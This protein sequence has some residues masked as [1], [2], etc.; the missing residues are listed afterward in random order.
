MLRD[1]SVDHCQPLKMFALIGLL[2]V[3]FLGEI[4]ANAVYICAVYSTPAST[5][6]KHTPKLV[7][8]FRIKGKGE[9]LKLYSNCHP[10]LF[11]FLRLYAFYFAPQTKSFHKNSV[12]CLCLSLWA[13]CSLLSDSTTPSWPLTLFSAGA[14]PLPLPFPMHL[15]APASSSIY[16]TVVLTLT[17]PCAAGPR[18]PLIFYLLLLCCCS[19]LDSLL[20]QLLTKLRPPVP[21]WCG[22]LLCRSSLT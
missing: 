4:A 15:P 18:P 10:L 5:D 13:P 20:L 9:Y 22:E 7:T 12:W 2:S 21:S 11:I 19:K 8:S 17:P 1:F 16:T 6:C 3:R 14:A